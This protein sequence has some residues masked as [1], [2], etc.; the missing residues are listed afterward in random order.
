MVHLDPQIIEKWCGETRSLSL[1]DA[2]LFPLQ[3]RGDQDVQRV[4]EERRIRVLGSIDF[5]P[6]CGVQQPPSSTRAF[7]IHWET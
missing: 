1:A 5:W 7:V 2:D 6:R 4:S 3:V